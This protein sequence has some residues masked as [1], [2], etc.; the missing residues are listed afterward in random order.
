MTTLIENGTLIDPISRVHTKCNLYIK[1]NKIQSVTSDRSSAD[2]VIDARGKIVA[3]GFIDVHMHE[4][5][6]NPDGTLDE[7]ILLSLLSMVPPA[8]VKGRG[9]GR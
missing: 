2:R 3:P 1:D 8:M 5:G 9:A 6:L 7:S 4:G